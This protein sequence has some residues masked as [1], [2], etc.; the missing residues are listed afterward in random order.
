RP[1]LFTGLAGRGRPW[2]P[3]A[4]LLPPMRHRVG[5][6]PLRT[7]MTRVTTRGLAAMKLLCLT[8]LLPA[9]LI[10]G[11]RPQTANTTAAT[12]PPPAPT[13]ANLPAEL[14]LKQRSTTPVPGAAGKLSVTVDDITRGQTMVSL[15]D[16]KQQAIMG[17]V[18]PS[19]GESST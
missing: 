17:L 13:I 12:C 5:A 19:Q 4:A 10:V 14:T 16:D 6:S 2:G 7:L 3:R 8:V 9:I 15:L 18:S 1:V 11:C